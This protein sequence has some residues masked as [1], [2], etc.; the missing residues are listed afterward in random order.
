VSHGETNEALLKVGATLV[1]DGTS[2]KTAWI[3]TTRGVAQA[4]NNLIN[5]LH[6]PGWSSKEHNNGQIR[7]NLAPN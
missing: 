5:I 4:V 2:S 1:A 7:E 6:S 3:D